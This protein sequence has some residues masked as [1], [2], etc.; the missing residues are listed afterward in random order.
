MQ[1]T[2]SMASSAEHAS[3]R[4]VEARFIAAAGKADQAPPPLHPE[5]AFAGR[6]NV[7]KSTLMNALMGRRNLVHTS[8][9]PGCTRTVNFFEARTAT[10]THVVLVDLPGYGYAKR[11]REDR[12]NWA[13]LIE[14]YL[15]SRANL[16]A[17]VLLVDARRDLQDD[18]RQ[19]FE[20]LQSP[21]RTARPP[22]GTILVATK[23]DTLPSSRRAARL[24]D[25]RHQSS[26]QIIGLSCTDRDATAT[27]WR[28]IYQRWL[29]APCTD[30]HIR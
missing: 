15:V 1:Q 10:N 4:I 30:E 12:R 11:S 21:A 28:E 29:C 8:S 19:L 25:L 22:L 5:V 18:D 16:R 24:R 17:V 7:G 27:L 20:V 9:T 3:I 26:L 13:P 2:H 6:S 14:D 23:V